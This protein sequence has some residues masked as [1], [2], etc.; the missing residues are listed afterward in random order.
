VST[1]KKKTDLFIIILFILIG[2]GLFGYT[3]YVA[4]KSI[5]D[6]PTKTK[7]LISLDLYG[8]KLNDKDTELFSSTFKE[9]EIVLNEDSIDYSKY[10]ELLSKLFVIDVFTLNNK[11]AST[12]IGGLDYLHK[13]LK[14]N[15]KENMGATLYK[16]VE[17]NL[18][19][20]R[21]QKLPE[22]S[23]INVTSIEETKYT[24]EKEEFDGYNV[25]LSWEYVEDLGYEKSIKLTLIRDNGKL[26]VVKGL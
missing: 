7:E 4:Y 20:T 1:A 8:Y 16:N 26:Y 14:E 5:T 6:T 13:D 21:T 12:D 11:L 17:N 23:S 9:L 22:V 24:Y 15:F 10:A 2:I 19:G 18:D 3:G 25:S